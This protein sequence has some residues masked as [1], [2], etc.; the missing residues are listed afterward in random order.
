MALPVAAI[1][2]IVAACGSS[3]N[4]GGGGSGGS[5]Q[6][7]TSLGT[8]IYGT[9]PPAGTPVKGGV[10]TQGQLNGQ[11]PTYIFPIVG[12]ANITS[13]TATFNS[14]LFMPLYAGPT[15][16]IPKV[17]FPLSFAAGPPQPSNGDKTFTIPLKQGLKWS[18]GQ[19]MTAN[20]LLFEY[21]LL[22][23][24]ITE[25]PANWAQFVPGGF[26]ADVTSASAPNNHTV[27]FNLNQ[28]NNPGFFE[29]N[30]LAD[31]DQVFA[32][33]SSAWNLTAPGQHVTN[34]QTP[35]VAKKVYD[36]LSKQGGSVATFASNPLWKTVSGPFELKSF[37]ATNSSYVLV[38]NPNYGGTPKPAMSEVDVN[39]YTDFT[40]ELNA[41]KSGALDVM[42]GVDPSQLAETPALKTQGID[43]FGG[44]SWG[45][46]GGIINNKDTTN[47]FN[48]VMKQVYVKAAI[49]H[50]IDQPG[51]IKGVYKN[52]AV[53][54][55]GP[56]PTAPT[57]PYAPS[58]AATAPYPYSPS[59]AVSLL[60]S[61]GWKVVP[62]GQTT[63]Q[64]A[65]TAANECG[66][67]IPAGTPLAFTWA[68]QP[69]SVSSVG[70]LESE[71]LSSA[72]KQYAGINIQL[73]TKTFNFLTSNYNNQNPAATKYTNDWGVN[74]YGGVFM[75]YYPTQYGIF[76]PGGGLN[77]GAYDDPTANSLINSSVHGGNA[78]A[79][80]TEASYF[81][82]NLPVFFFPDQDYLVAVNTKKVG[83][84]APGWTVM[85]QQQFFPQFW[86]QIKG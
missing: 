64:K 59:A 10:I 81:E 38:P 34:W 6:A 61:H 2:L 76:N 3:N 39:T 21:Y 20:D 41:V 52:A 57:S 24:A 65:G 17:S 43:V 30:Q 26:P 72:A 78:N 71:A 80:K 44:P 49:D 86:Y 54:A 13:D 82:K 42:V 1:A 14:E 29:N 73:V 12:N 9:L 62:G 7:N 51:I 22:K 35:A 60:K 40:S 48:M 28:P 32:L 55:Y 84:P 33:P 18:N 31:T 4:S 37:S 25:S 36:F 75:D 15:G 16:A 27:V 69:Q 56:T 47:H 74:N 19:P 68:N 66:A 58:D 85:T 5:N 8:V 53:P 11:T 77:I 23:A 70:A 46:F 67:G 79:V 50:L 63:C 45:W 83:G